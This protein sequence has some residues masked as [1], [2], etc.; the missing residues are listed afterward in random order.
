MGER[1]VVGKQGQFY[2]LTAIVL[3]TYAFMIVRPSPIL[4]EK[5]DVFKEL[6][7][8]FISESPVVVNNALYDGANVSQR[9]AS[10]AG[11]YADY[12]VTRSPNFR[13]LYILR[14]DTF[15]LVG[16]RLGVSVNVTSAGSSYAV[17]DRSTL[18]I[19]PADVSVDVAGI[20]YAFSIGPETY[21]V[22]SLFRQKNDEG[23]RIYVNN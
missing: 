9:F 22:K 12:S 2:I 4:Q 7:Q 1:K 6:Y 13:F 16:N 3:L 8:N 10:F 14:D 20:S 23:T 15:M 11:T 19:S 17:A 21:Q 5:R 18:T